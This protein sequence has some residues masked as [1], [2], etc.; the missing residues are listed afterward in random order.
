MADGFAFDSV[1]LSSE[2]DND[3]GGCGAFMWGGGGG[4][5]WLGANVELDVPESQWGGDCVCTSL[6]VL[7]RLKQEEEGDPGEL[8]NGLLLFGAALCCGVQGV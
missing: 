6:A 4:W 2:E 5:G 8:V 1:L 7:T 3:G